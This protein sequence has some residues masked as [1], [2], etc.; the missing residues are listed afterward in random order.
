MT[1]PAQGKTN[2]QAWIFKWL[3]NLIGRNFEA[4]PFVLSL[5]LLYVYLFS[6]THPW[7]KIKVLK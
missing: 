6:Q 2:V 1:L 5:L 4:L 3:Q 7:Y